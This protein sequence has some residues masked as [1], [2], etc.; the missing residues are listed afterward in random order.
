MSEPRRAKM[1]DLSLR[2]KADGP[3]GVPLVNNLRF[4]TTAH[5]Y[6]MKAM[7]PYHEQPVVPVTTGNGSVVVGLGEAAV[8]QVSTDQTTFHRAGEGL[9]VV[10]QGQRYSRM[11]DAIITANEG[12]H[13]RRRKLLMPIVHRSA[14]E[15]YRA[16]FE[17]TFRASLFVH[18]PNGEPFDMVAE[19]LRMSK[20]NMLRGMLGVDDTPE[21]HH[22]ASDVLA[23]STTAARPEVMLL[24]WNK[25]LMPYGKWVARVAAS[26]D[27]LAALVEARLADPVDRLDALSIVCA[28]TYDDGDVLT[29]SEIA[30]EL[31]GL[32]SAGFETTAM[33]TMWALLLM[34]AER[35]E[36]DP[37]DERSLDAIVKESQRLLPAVP[38][39]LP[40]RLTAEASIG[41]SAP[42][43]AGA[44]LWLSAAVDQHRADV[45]PEPYAYRPERWLKTPP[46]PYSFFPFGIG[47][48][49]CLG[50]AFAELQTRVTLGLLAKEGRNLRL[51]T[52]KVDYRIVSG[53]VSAPRQPIMVQFAHER[54]VPPVVTGS[55]R[56]LWHQ[57][58]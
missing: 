47:A 35:T 52:N 16:I 33:T 14:M 54:N 13:R 50:A 4:M 10:P 1:F 18:A 8:Q 46:R 6:V 58:R 37:T 22:L 36:L 41:G 12:D 53:V 28:S 55:T 9:F 40:R 23:L 43:P 49:R 19:L 17:E 38:M 30:G 31:H 45:Y 7:A 27:R 48:R 51:L 15:H 26:Y 11:F 42:I 32:V 29:T 3:S 39:S 5:R 2:M 56:L 24:P 44:L 34:L 21:N 20:T 57:T 25:S